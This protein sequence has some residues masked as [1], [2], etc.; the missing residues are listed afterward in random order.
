[1]GKIVEY[2]FHPR[3]A[4]NEYKHTKHVPRNE[5]NQENKMTA[6]ARHNYTFTHAEI[7]NPE[8]I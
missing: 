6:T 3:F 7:N 2:T 1:M 5:F 4:T 8:N